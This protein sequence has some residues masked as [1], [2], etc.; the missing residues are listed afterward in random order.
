MPGLATHLIFALSISALFTAGTVLIDLDHFTMCN[1]KA[2]ATY[3]VNQEKGSAMLDA[4]GQENCRGWPHTWRWGIVLITLTLAWMLHMF[5][6]YILY[7]ATVNSK[8]PF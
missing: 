8:L 5:L 1:P 7:P 3:A 2:I 6:D 4:L